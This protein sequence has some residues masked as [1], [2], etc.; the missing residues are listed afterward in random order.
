MPTGIYIRTKKCREILSKAHLGEKHTKEHNRKISETLLKHNWN[1]NRGRKQSNEV[2]G[3]ISKSMMGR[4]ITWNNKIKK[5][6]KGKYTNES[7]SQWKGDF[8]SYTGLHEWIKRKLG[9]PSK[10][11][12]NNKHKAKRY[13]W[14]NISGEYKRDLSDWHELCQ[15]CN[16][17]DGIHIAKKFLVLKEVKNNY[18]N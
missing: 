3:K 13:V 4:K 7:N 5:A 10:C 11:S 16:T 18:G 2:K 8:V 12:N 6:L 17:L 14:A 9:N 1:W 15:S